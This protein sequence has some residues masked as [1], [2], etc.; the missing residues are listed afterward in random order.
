MSFQRQRSSLSSHMS[1]SSVASCTQSQKAS[2]C[3]ITGVA[4]Q[5]QQTGSYSLLPFYCNSLSPPSV[6]GICDVSTGG[7]LASGR[8]CLRTLYRWEI[9]V[10]AIG[11]SFE[12]VFP[13][14]FLKASETLRK[15]EFT[16]V[17]HIF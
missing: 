5:A 7:T 6:D 16:H 17:K 2:F 10:Q 3:C 9:K 1:L 13:W 14:S 4:S 11:M 15:K 8:S 12:L